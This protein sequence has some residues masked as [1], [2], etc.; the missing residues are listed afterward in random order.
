MREFK[1][2]PSKRKKP[3]NGRKRKSV[4]KSVRNS[5][6]RTNLPY[7]YNEQ[8]VRTMME[9]YGRIVSPVELNNIIN[10]QRNLRLA[11]FNIAPLPLNMP[12]APFNIA[13]LPLDDMPPA[14]LILQRQHAGL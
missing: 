10:E 9:R 13:P 8:T 7:N 6:I 2:F 1:K 12:P 5:I 3:I 4:R 14:P 11:P